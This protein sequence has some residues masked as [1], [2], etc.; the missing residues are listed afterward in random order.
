MLCRKGSEQ[1]PCLH[2]RGGPLPPARIASVVAACSNRRLTMSRPSLTSSSTI[3]A[4]RATAGAHAMARTRPSLAGRIGTFFAL[5]L[6]LFAAAVVLAVAGAVNTGLRSELLVAAGIAVVAAGLASAAVLLRQDRQWRETTLELKSAEA[7][8]NELVEAAMDPIV[9][10]DADQRVVTF[11]AA[12]E[13]VFQRSR[14]AVIGQSLDILVPARLRE[15]HRKHID[16]FAATGVT[17]RRMGAHAVLTA[18]RADGSEFPI[19]ASISQHEQDGQKRFT[20]ILRDVS[21]RVRGQTML[22][23]SEARM[24][25]ILDSAMDAIVTVDDDQRVV[26]FNAAAESMF[27][28]TRREAMGLPLDTFI[29]ERFRGVHGSHVRQYGSA[30]SAARRMGASRIVT[31]LRRNGEEFPIDASISQLMD[32][33]TRY[34][35]VILRDVSERMKAHEAL[36]RSKEELQELTSTSHI[37]REQEK[38][39]IAR[40]LHDELGQALTMLQMDVAWCKAKAPAG[41]P[42]FAIRLDRMQTLLKS[43]VAAT[44]RIAADLR[45]LLLDD[46]GIVPAVEWLA[47]NFT[48]RTGVPCRLTIEDPDLELDTVRATAVFRIVQESLTN[49]AKHAGAADAEVSIAQQDDSLVIR[50]RDDG[51]GFVAQDPRKPGSFGLVG[52][53]ERAALLRGDATITS[54]IGEGTTIEVRLPL[55]AEGART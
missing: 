21:E 50:V 34:Y 1:Q 9:I 12:A 38:N 26:L 2:P 45:P 6:A 15:A 39:R 29:P 52:L 55:G 16:R 10:V 25:G 32:G 46:L 33:D 31:G 36:R 35:T 24:R 4:R 23:R 14:L 5:I 7:H 51:K 48:Q 44:R 27:L 54:G 20:V 40:E 28:Y 53:R 43:T 47:E 3:P 8:V 42:E 11:N 49:I 17:S 19:E 37:A 13:G 41:E 18:L 22:A 30:D